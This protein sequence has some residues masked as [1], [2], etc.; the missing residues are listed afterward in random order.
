[1]ITYAYVYALYAFAYRVLNGAEQTN[2]R[3]E[4]YNWEQHSVCASKVID[5]IGR[6]LN[7]DRHARKLLAA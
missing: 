2:V 5:E 3:Y 4:V 7:V 6:A 1:M